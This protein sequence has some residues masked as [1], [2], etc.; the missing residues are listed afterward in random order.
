[1]SV[2]IVEIAARVLGTVA[3]AGLVS[4]SAA[5]S[6]TPGTTLVADAGAT[7]SYI[8]EADSYA[9]CLELIQDHPHLE[10][11]QTIAVREIDPVPEQ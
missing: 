11:G 4:C 9:H 2:R 8:V 7:H 10:Y 3:L 6:G 1:M 5:P